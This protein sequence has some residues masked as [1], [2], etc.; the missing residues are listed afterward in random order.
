MH[1]GGRS[2]PKY[3]S[4]AD[5][6]PAVAFAASAADRKRLLLER[7]LRHG[8]RRARGSISAYWRLAGAYWKGPM[9]PQARCLMLISLV[10]VVG[11]IGVNYGINLWNRAFFNALQ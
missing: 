8:Q 2:Q 3:R 10:L 9:A 1:Y 7:P 5:I 11:N 4:N 6:R